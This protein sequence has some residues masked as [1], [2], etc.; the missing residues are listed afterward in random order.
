MLLHSKY[1]ISGPCRC[2]GEDCI[3]VFCYIRLYK[4]CDPF[5][6]V[7][8]EPMGECLENNVDGQHTM[9]HTKYFTSDGSGFSE[10]F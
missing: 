1:Y 5:N 6:V 10:D 4:S 2:K 7:N 9:L 8:V 3:K